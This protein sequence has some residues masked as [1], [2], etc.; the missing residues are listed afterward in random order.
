MSLRRHQTQILIR[1]QARSV[2]RI[3]GK[4]AGLQR[5]KE[6]PAKLLCDMTD[7]I[8]STYRTGEKGIE[9]VTS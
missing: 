8:C 4:A 5:G 7:G 1:P 6:R 2:G 9:P 3:G